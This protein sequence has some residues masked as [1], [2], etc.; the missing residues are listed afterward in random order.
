MIITLGAYVA[1]FYAHFSGKGVADPCCAPNDQDCGN[2]SWT[3]VILSSSF[4]ALHDLLNIYNLTIDLYRKDMYEMYRGRDE[5]T[6][7]DRKRPEGP[8]GPSN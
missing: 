6:A 4:N 5:R 2:F 7:L 3:L 1:L 8:S